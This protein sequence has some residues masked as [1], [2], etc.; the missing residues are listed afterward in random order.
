M[1]ATLDFP[2]E[3]SDILLEPQS[4]T[5]RQSWPPVDMNNVMSSTFESDDARPHET[6]AI[7]PCD[8]C[9]QHYQERLY[10][11]K[12]AVRDAH[13]FTAPREAGSTRDRPS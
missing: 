2:H 13:C 11:V 1:N 7:T 12:V 9:S 10:A 4:L 6:A 5:A 3:V 8:G